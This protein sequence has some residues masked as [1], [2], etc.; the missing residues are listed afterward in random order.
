MRSRVDGPCR[1]RA[2][3]APVRLGTAT[4]TSDSSWGLRHMSTILFGNFR[5]EVIRHAGTRVERATMQVTSP[6]R[7]RQPQPHFSPAPMV[8]GRHDQVSDARRAI[9]EGRPIGFHAPCGFGVSTL[10]RHIAASDFVQDSGVPVVLLRVGRDFA[11]DVLQRLVDQL[12]VSDRRIKLTST[13]LG[14][15]LG[16]L[17]AVVILD[18]LLLNSEEAEFILGMLP[19]CSVVTGSPRAILDRPRTSRPLP[20]LSETAALDL[21]S[22]CLARAPSGA[23]QLQARRLIA[24]VHGQPLHLKQAAALVRSGQHT[25]E[26]LANS[27]ERDPGRLD[28]LCISRIPEAERKILTILTM[29]AGALIPTD[30]IT[31][32][33]DITDAAQRLRGL[34]HHGLAE[35]HDDRFGLPI[36]NATRYRDILLED[37]QV[38]S[39]ARQLASWLTTRDPASPDSVAALEAALC[40]VEFAAEQRE[41][42]TVIS[43]I[44]AVE[45]ILALAGRWEA[46]RHVLDMGI[47]AAHLIGD[48][49]SEALFCHEQGTR[50]LCKDELGPA[51]Q[52]LDRA[53][54][55]REQAGDRAGASVT[56]ANRRL[57]QPEPAAPEPPR[58]SRSDRTSITIAG[59]L[60]VILASAAIGLARHQAN[61][62]PAPIVS[63]G[64]SPTATP[65]RT[66]ATHPQPSNSGP[67]QGGHT[68]GGPTRGGHTQ[69]GPTHG[70]PTRSGNTTLPD[71]VPYTSKPKNGGVLVIIENIGTRAAAASTT[72]VDFGSLGPASS[73]A[74]PPIPAG[75]SQIISFEDPSACLTSGCT[76]TVT[77]NSDNTVHESNTDNNQKTFYIFGGGPSPDST[78]PSPDSTSPSPDSTSPSPDSTSPS[79]DSTSPSPDYA[80]SPTPASF[81]ATSSAGAS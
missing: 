30:L 4:K 23:E 60:A 10:L 55:L 1:H 42:T 80:E 49:A 17:R 69:G 63:H 27:A 6:V 44:R 19:R 50:A 40:L 59:I 48:T 52:Y 41:W 35:Q 3:A 56:A 21:V 32:M 43:L 7:R 51:Q 15:L 29:A 66:A 71:L 20:G 53:L 13:E 33:S 12:Y 81:P 2:T 61:A 68:Q 47:N 38:G 54:Q 24:A 28:R 75:G 65:S 72:T 16:Q 8:Y 62:A 78:S 58:P 9:E 34:C 45:P 77:V 73:S 74:T 46:W 79:P 36:C 57:L 39:A 25:F 64:P 76:Y 22:G 37:L 31:V 14:R 5:V 18:D 67:A 70:G 11:G 26:E